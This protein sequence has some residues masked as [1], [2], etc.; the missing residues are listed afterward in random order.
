MLKIKQIK[1]NWAVWG[2]NPQNTVNQQWR[3]IGVLPLCWATV[4][5]RHWIIPQ[6]AGHDSFIIHTGPC[7]SLPLH[8][9]SYRALLNIRI[10]KVPQ[11]IVLKNLTSSISLCRKL[12][13]LINLNDGPESLVAKQTSPH[14]T[15]M[16]SH[17]QS[18]VRVN[19]PLSLTMVW[20]WCHN[21]QH[22]FFWQL[23]PFFRWK[24][25]L[26]VNLLKHCTLVKFCT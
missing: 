25:T 2:V 5:Y 24:L 6:C 19:P 7:P 21:M 26:V 8:S 20:K 4:I 23:T 11:R 12:H 18:W 22:F 13:L 14:L 10:W 16:N 1:N 9:C 3:G 15:M 17:A